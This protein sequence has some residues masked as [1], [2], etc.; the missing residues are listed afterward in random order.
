MLTGSGDCTLLRKDP[1]PPRDPSRHRRREPI[2]VLVRSIVAGVRRRASGRT[3]WPRALA[4]VWM[5]HIAIDLWDDP[6][7]PRGLLNYPN[8]FAGLNLGIHEFGHAVFWPLGELMGFAGGSLLQCLAPIAGMV[9]FARQRDDFAIAVALT[10][11][12][13]NVFSVGVY[14]A[15]AVVRELPLVTPFGGEP[16]HDWVTIFTRLGLMDQAAS[17]GMAMKLGAMA[18]IGLGLVLGGWIVFEAWRT[19]HEDQ[20]HA[21]F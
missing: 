12:G 21:V 4:L 7:K 6:M 20:A 15:D 2:A 13:T 17:I 5:T 18:W 9:M 3:W 11:L 10:W 19:R 8:V 14:M 1:M 16:I